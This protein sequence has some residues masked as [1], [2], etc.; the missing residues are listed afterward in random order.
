MLVSLSC[1]FYYC[2][3]RFPLSSTACVLRLIHV[4]WQENYLKARPAKPRKLDGPEHS[5]KQLEL[6]SKASRAIS[7]GDLVD[8]IIHRFVLV[9]LIFSPPV[10]GRLLCVD[11][12]ADAVLLS[13]AR[14]NI[15]PWCLS[16]RVATRS[17][18]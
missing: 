4:M 5:L 17:V 6:M 2:P 10:S 18:D 13:A 7:D 14:N 16:I 15:G 3:W 8:R 9:L 11:I 12:F 1:L